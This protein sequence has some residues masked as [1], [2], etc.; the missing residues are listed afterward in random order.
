VLSRICEG[1]CPFKR[2]CRCPRSN[3]WMWN[4]DRRERVA[5]EDFCRAFLSHVLPGDW[6]DN[7]RR[8]CVTLLPKCTQYIGFLPFADYK[9]SPDYVKR[10]K[11]SRKKNPWGF[12]NSPMY[13]NGGCARGNE[14]ITVAGRDLAGSCAWHRGESEHP[15]SYHSS[16]SLSRSL[17]LYHPEETSYLR[18]LM[19]RNEDWDTFLARH[20]N[21]PN[22][23]LIKKHSFGF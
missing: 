6:T 9:P 1:V 19:H 18:M 3:D 8:T 15:L 2:P 21:H 12:R 14:E 20:S 5:A 13:E 7:N 10:K 22:Q 11:K 17:P 23:S 16:I 4:R